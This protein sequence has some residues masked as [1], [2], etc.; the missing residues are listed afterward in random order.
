MIQRS[1]LPDRACHFDGLLGPRS[2]WSCSSQLTGSTFMSQMLFFVLYFQY[3]FSVQEEGEVMVSLM[4]EDTRK[5]KERGVENL[6]IGYFVMKVIKCTVWVWY[7]A[8]LFLHTRCYGQDFPLSLIPLFYLQ[9]E[10]NRKYRVHT[11]FEK[12][13]DSIFINAREVVNKLELKKGRYLVI[14]STYEPN[15]AGRYLIRVFTEKS[16][17]AM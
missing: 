1:L 16:S 9:V 8:V 14:P 6:T 13:G 12:A 7:G 10:E 4:Q 2:Y 3:A 11:M 17:K 15:K 5:E